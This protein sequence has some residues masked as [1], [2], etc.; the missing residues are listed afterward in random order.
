M[1]PNII[2]YNAMFTKKEVAKMLRCC[3]RTVEYRAKMGLL[4]PTKIGRHVL[5]SASDNPVLAKIKK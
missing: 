4:K 2:K 1:E 5:F 3:I